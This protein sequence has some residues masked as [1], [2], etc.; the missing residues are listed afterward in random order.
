MDPKTALASG[1][2]IA[3]R[4]RVENAVPYAE[5]RAAFVA[6]DVASNDRV[7]AFDAELA[8][9]DALRAGVG[10]HHK[11]L[12]T[13]RGLVAHG[14]RDVLL[15]DYV[16]GLT[17]EAFADGTPRLS[18]VDTVRFTLRALDALL[19]LHHAGAVHGFLRPACVI[20]EPEGRP[21]PVVAFAPPPLQVS[22]YHSPER[23]AAGP[24]SIA[25][26]SWAAGALL[27]RMLTGRDPP[28]AG[29]G[30]ADELTLAG[31][32]DEILR[33]AL[34]HALASDPAKR[35]ED[36]QPLRRE[37]ARWFAEHA[38]DDAGHSSMSLHTPP[39]L[40]AGASGPPASSRVID[41]P[42][43]SSPSGAPGL[44]T[45]MRSPPARSRKGLMLGLAGAAA[46]VGLGA[47]WGVSALRAKPTVKTVAIAATPTGEAVPATTAV[48]LG[49]VAVT[50]DTEGDGGGDRLAS[51][52][53][54]HLPKE[55]FRKQP[56]VS[57]LCSENDPRAGGEKLRV[58]IVQGAAGGA[59]TSAMK[60]VSRIGWYE[61]ALFAVARESCCTE[62]KALELPEPSK[63]CDPMV[64][65]LGAVSKSVAARQ[66]VDEALAAF[67]KTAR[68]ETDA[69]KAS[70]FRRTAAPTSAEQ[71]AFKELLESVDA[72]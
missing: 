7:L 21:R 5:A 43:A 62:A 63:G 37:L 4:F 71:A 38:G 19:A 10:I 66:H 46:V 42:P 1:V 67:E 52:V 47:A 32:D 36:L 58:A 56:D 64:K 14:E 28:A 23:G 44:A 59:P 20:L 18:R 22:A 55:A 17:V 6:T 65:N 35:S 9:G 69:K 12:A 40:P 11:H 61:M 57:W 31:V 51:C 53:S 3:E 48:S 29:V 50:G 2:V 30:S 15:S 49:E 16:P 24:P 26:D 34:V 27:F 33:E 68:C 60:I 25:D 8:A 13:V 70:L 39:P 41:V 54:N 45:S 72:P